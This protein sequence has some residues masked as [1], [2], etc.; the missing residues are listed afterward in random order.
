MHL[1]H[2][3]RHQCAEDAYA[4]AALLLC[5]QPMENDHGE[6]VTLDTLPQLS[7]HLRQRCCCV[8]ATVTP[9]EDASSTAATYR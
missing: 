3:F 8:L 9:K 4:E 1:C 5:W 7:A 2:R 6:D